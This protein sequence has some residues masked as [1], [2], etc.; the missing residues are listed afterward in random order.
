MGIRAKIKFIDNEE[1]YLNLYTSAHHYGYD[2]VLEAIFSL[3]SLL[4]MGTHRFDA[5]VID[6]LC[7]R[8]QELK[9]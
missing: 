9:S 7:K 6:S 8:A 5:D 2:V 1:T 4:D 3:L